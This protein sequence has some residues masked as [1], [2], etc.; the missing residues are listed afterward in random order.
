MHREGSAVFSRKRI[1]SSDF[2]GGK[3]PTE[4][5]AYFIAEAAHYLRLST[6]T[7]RSWVLGREYQTEAGP[8]VSTSLILAVDPERR[9]LSFLNLVELHV[10]SSI[11]RVHQVKPRAVR[12][13]IVYLRRKFHSKHPLLDRQMLTD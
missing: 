8:T 1:S 6:T 4:M 10:L 7:I 2:Y 9:L 3:N 13:A 11:R 5:P 12:K